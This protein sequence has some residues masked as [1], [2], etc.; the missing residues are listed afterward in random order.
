[1]RTGIDN[2]AY[3]HIEAAK[4]LGMKR[5]PILFRVVFPPALAS[6][7]P[8]LVGQFVLLLQSSSLLS[9]ISVAELMGAAN[10]IQSLTVRNFEA[11]VVVGA[12]YITLTTIIRLLLASVGFAAFPRQHIGA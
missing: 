4:A 5:F 12:F 2:V 11:F 6:V 1:L 10:D 9:A 8:A 7:F 3:G